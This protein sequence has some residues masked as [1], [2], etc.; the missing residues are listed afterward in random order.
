MDIIKYLDENLPDLS[1]G[2][3]LLLIDFFNS[4][5]DFQLP[6]KINVAV[7]GGGKYQDEIKVLT[8]MG[9]DVTVKVF[10]IEEEEVFF[11]LNVINELSNKEFFD[12]IICTQVLEHIWNHESFFK[13]LEKISSPKSILY[14]DCPKSN[15]VHMEPIYYS[16]GFTSSY[17][18]KNLENN[19]FK[20]LKSGE[21]GGE[22]NY[23]SIHVTQSWYN[24]EAT[25]K[26]YRFNKKGFFYRIKHLSKLSNLGQFLVLRMNNN[27]Q[28]EEF[29][30]QSYVFATKS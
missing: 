15:K 7:V 19:S 9:F 22:V 30:T 28:T 10:G 23:K 14:I 8:Q 6:P 4:I 12:L 25:L 29:M 13:N 2:R 11:D 17:L 18:I 24:K 1:Y 27:R 20:I 3:H 16:S 21:L 5:K 26:R